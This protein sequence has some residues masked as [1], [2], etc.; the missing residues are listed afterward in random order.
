MPSVDP[1]VWCSAMP[2][3]KSWLHHGARAGLVHE[4]LCIATKPSDPM[5]QAVVTPEG[6]GLV[7]QVLGIQSGL[8]G[9]QAE[10]RETGPGIMAILS[11]SCV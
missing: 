3:P 8:E 2:G 6:V 9:G 4:Q 5:F 1:L 11:E 10:S 7:A